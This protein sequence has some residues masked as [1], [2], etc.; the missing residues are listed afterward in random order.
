MVGPLVVCVTA[1][2][3]NE[4]ETVPKRRGSFLYRKR[5]REISVQCCQK[6]AV[7]AGNPRWGKLSNHLSAPTPNMWKF[8]HLQYY[9][10][11]VEHKNDVP[12]GNFRYP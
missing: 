3:I 4:I 2:N 7:A 8:T 1:T 11:S 9:N 5:T 12:L 10:E 6:V